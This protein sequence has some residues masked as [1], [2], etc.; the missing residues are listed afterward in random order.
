MDKQDKHEKQQDKHDM[1]ISKQNFVCYK[2]GNITNDYSIA[3][4]L[5]SGSFGTVRKAVHKLTGQSRAIKILKKSEQD[6]NKLFLEVEI[7]CRLAH[8]NIMQIYEFYDDNKNFYIVSEF[9]SGGELFDTISEKGALT[10]VEAAYMMKQ[11][12]SAIFY[13]HENN[14]VHRDLKPENILLDDKSEK[15]LIKLIDWGGGKQIFNFSS[16]L[17]KIQK[18]VKSFRN[19]LL[20]RSR[21]PF[22][23]LR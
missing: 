18:N 11:I 12:L 5:G 13:S 7:L 3:S 21:G 20:Y 4:N 15:P 17:L 8:P 2:K 6:E 19:S 1:K 16:L 10:E 14:I 23:I 9:C 22:R